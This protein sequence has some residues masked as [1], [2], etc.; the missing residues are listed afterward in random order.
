MKIRIVRESKQDVPYE[1]RQYVDSRQDAPD[2]AQVYSGDQEDTWYYDVRET[3]EQEEASTPDVSVDDIS[4]IGTS[5]WED[6]EKWE[7]VGEQIPTEELERYYEDQ[8]YGSDKVMVRNLLYYREDSDVDINDCVQ[9]RETDP[10]SEADTEMIEDA[11]RR[12][13]DHFTDGRGAALMKSIGEINAGKSRYNGETLDGKYITIDTEWEDTVSHEI[14]HVLLNNIG[15]DGGNRQNNP[16]SHPSTW[17]FNLRESRHAK[18]DKPMEF[19]SELEDLWEI[20]V[21]RKRQ[22]IDDPAIEE[23]YQRNQISNYQWEDGSEF[24]CELFSA[25]THRRIDLESIYPEAADLF[26]DEF[27]DAWEGRE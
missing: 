10:K 24:F 5:H 27:G 1:Y 9:I 20:A 2:D 23:E 21:E 14:G 3:E 25:W 8:E 19:L 22:D 26:G 18:G 17:S 11:T 7:A 4:D 12:V 16:D 6:I 15:I 13:I